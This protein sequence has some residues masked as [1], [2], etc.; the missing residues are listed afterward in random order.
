[1]P[2][3]IAR[4]HKAT[5]NLTAAVVFLVIGEE[6][7]RQLKNG[8]LG[9]P[10]PYVKITEETGCTR[11]QVRFALEV[12]RDKKLLEF[13]QKLVGNKNVNVF[14][15]TDKAL[16]VMGGDGLDEFIGEGL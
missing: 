15:L 8:V 12:I 11:K 3:C 9:V 7:R 6:C 16:K 4:A 2:N 1:M 5:G 14:R 13:S 10:F